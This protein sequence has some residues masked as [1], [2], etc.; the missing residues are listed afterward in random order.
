MNKTAVKNY[1]VE[2]RKKWIQAIA[3]QAP[4]MAV[5]KKGSL[6]DA[7]ITKQLADKGVFSQQTKRAPEAPS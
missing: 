5:P 3:Q 6:S 7:E 4:F 2:A 1:A